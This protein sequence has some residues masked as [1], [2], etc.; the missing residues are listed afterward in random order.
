LELVCKTSIKKVIVYSPDRLCRFSHELLEAV[1]RLHGTEIVYLSKEGEERSSNE[2]L[3]EDILSI[4]T[5]FSARYHGR[6]K[7]GESDGSEKSEDEK[8]EDKS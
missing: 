7:Y 3:A 2:E 6:R 8:D 5:L 1:F 4:V